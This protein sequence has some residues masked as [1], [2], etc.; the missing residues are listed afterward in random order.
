MSSLI[1][2]LTTAYNAERYIGETIECILNQD[3]TNF[4]YVIVDDGSKDKTA[5]IVK[6]YSDP[7]LRLIEVGRIGRGKALNQAINESRGEY[8]A[9]QDADDI[10][11]PRRLSTEIAYLKK[12]NDQGL[13][14]ASTIIFYDD[15]TPIWPDIN[16]YQINTEV[17]VDSKDGLVYFNPISHTSLMIPKFILEKVGRY[18]QTRKNLYD[19]DLYLR[20]AA[21][22]FGIYQLSLPLVG[23]RLHSKQYFERKDRVTYLFDCM[24]L[25]INA[26]ILFKRYG[27]PLLSIPIL[28]FYRLAPIKLR[29][30]S[31]QYIRKFLQR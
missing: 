26:A 3:Y 23:K 15:Q 7:R 18:D 28:F 1:S 10:S 2:V 4:E 31:R 16:D 6:T 20:V 21:H 8:I 25:Q 11:H 17:L 30:S 5:A 19:W 9:I 22:G 12:N 29:I 14:G 27:L 24:K 13:I